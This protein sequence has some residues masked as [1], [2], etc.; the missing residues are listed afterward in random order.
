[1]KTC[2]ICFMKCPK[3]RQYGV[4]KPYPGGSGLYRC[5]HCGWFG[6]KPP[7]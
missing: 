5:L 4:Y 1:M 6:E 7:R 3:C 2:K